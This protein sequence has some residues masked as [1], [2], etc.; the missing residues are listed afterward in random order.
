MLI[1]SFANGFTMCTL[2]KYVSFNILKFSW[3]PFWLRFDKS[4]GQQMPFLHPNC[5]CGIGLG[6]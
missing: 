5:G 1:I 2:S 6:S 3:F 4:D